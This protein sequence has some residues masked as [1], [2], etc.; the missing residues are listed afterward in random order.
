MA[1]FFYLESNM[2]SKNFSGLA[3]VTT[4]LAAAA[5]LAACGGGGSTPTS[6]AS[7]GSTFTPLTVVQNQSGTTHSYDNVG[8][9]SLPGNNTAGGYEFNVTTN[10][11][12]GVGTDSVYR[13]VGIATGDTGGVGVYVA[14]AG[15]TTWSINGATSITV[16][17][18]TN[19]TCVGVCKATLILNNATDTNCKATINTPITIL[20]ESVNT[21]NNA[22]QVSGAV[23]VYTATLTDANWTVSGCTTNTMTA[24][25]LLPI[26]EIHAQLLRANMQTTTVAAGDTKYANGLN[27][28]G[29]KFQ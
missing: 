21:G 9:T 23:P 6:A 22:T 19:P 1:D 11:W 29:I 17:L 26:K 15:A 18:G 16:G 24:F 20:T 5:I 14:G 3:L 12:S 10:W 7:T 13:G 25:K 8:G 28:G 27:L 2:K 4:T